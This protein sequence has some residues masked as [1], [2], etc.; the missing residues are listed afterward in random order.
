M[1]LNLLYALFRL[2]Y[3]SFCWL[4]APGLAHS[5]IP[6]GCKAEGVQHA[7]TCR[8]PPPLPALQK[9]GCHEIFQNKLTSL[10]TTRPA[11]DQL[12]AVV[13]AG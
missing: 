10:A 7:M 5:L 9:I 12:L 2:L 13:E 8:T 4:N 3:W 1:I 11:R 6:I